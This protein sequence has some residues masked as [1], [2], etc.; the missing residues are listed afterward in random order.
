LFIFFHQ[1]Y[2]TLVAAIF[3]DTSE[4][5]KRAAHS[6]KL[7]NEMILSNEKYVWPSGRGIMR[8]YSITPH[9]KSVEHTVQKNT[10]L[11]E[12]LAMVEAIRIG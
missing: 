5:I 8:G 11:H 12:L 2:D 9:Y 3:T 1:D 7:L 6:A 10:L 4:V